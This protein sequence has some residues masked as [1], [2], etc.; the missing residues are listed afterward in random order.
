MYGDYLLDDGEITRRHIEAA[1]AGHAVVPWRLLGHMHASPM[2]DVGMT[3]EH[4]SVA[5]QQCNGLAQ[6]HAD[7]RI[8]PFKDACIDQPEH[9]PEKRTVRRIDA[10]R[11]EHHM[12]AGDASVSGQ[13]DEQS[14]V[15]V[16]AKPDEVIAVRQIE[17]SRIPVPRP[18]QQCSGCIDQGD[19]VSLRQVPQAA[20]EELRRLFPGES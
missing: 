19:R 13:S 5:V 9:D 10:P 15:V 16:V 4:Y 11:N 3:R 2:F 14:P 1:P 8:E 7:F 20:H 18:A 6:D 17:P 12:L